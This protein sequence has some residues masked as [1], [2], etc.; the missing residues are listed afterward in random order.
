MLM[1]LEGQMELRFR[2]G[3]DDLKARQIG[4]EQ[5]SG[6]VVP[7]TNL[8]SETRSRANKADRSP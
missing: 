6:I 1:N 4:A 2:P 7:S 3:E 8:E 5:S